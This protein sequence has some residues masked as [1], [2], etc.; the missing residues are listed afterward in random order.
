[1]P[2][3]ANRSVSDNQAYVTVVTSDS[4]VSGALVLA[5]SLAEVS[6]TRPAI[7][8]YTRNLSEQS[9][10]ALN[11]AFH[12]CLPVDPIRSVN[13]DNLALLGRPEL[14]ISYTKFNVWRLTQ[15]SK[16]VFMD[17]DTMVLQNIDDLFERPEFSAAPDVGW[18]DCFN[19]GVFVC[20]PND[21]TY[22]RLVAFAQDN[23]S[24]D[25]G[26]QGLLND[27]FADWAKSPEKRLPFVYNVTPSTVYTYSPAYRRFR[28]E[29][30]VVHFIGYGK[31]WTFD[32]SFDGTPISHGKTSD[33][34]LSLIGKWWQLYTKNFSH[35]GNPNGMKDHKA[36]HTTHGTSGS[37]YNFGSIV[38]GQSGWSYGGPSPMHDFHNYRIEWPSDAYPTEQFS[39]IT[40]NDYDDQFEL[41]ERAVK[42]RVSPTN[43]AFSPG[44]P[45][46]F[47]KENKLGSSREMFGNKMQ[48]RTD[49][50]MSSAKS[51]IDSSNFSS[52]FSPIDATNQ[53]KVSVKK[54]EPAK[55]TISSTPSLSTESRSSQKSAYSQEKEISSKPR[56][57]SPSSRPI[58][59]NDRNER[60][61]EPHSTSNETSN[62]SLT[63]NG[64]G[65]VPAK[66]VLSSR[67]PS[68][69]KPAADH[70]TSMKSGVSLS[71]ETE[72]ISSHKPSTLSSSLNGK[73]NRQAVPPKPKVSRKK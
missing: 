46:N 29:I 31:P 43:S 52:A 10:T 14:D 41:I 11:E 57:T 22:N 55:P 67:Q 69:K 38:H 39:L 63:A 44:L 37:Y 64:N 12:Q 2:I 19:S 20:V 32:R 15:F 4:Y 30:K 62:Y 3:S 42:L 40:S 54:Q 73:I 47:D 25:G 34:V 71:K 45:M 66:P 56:A 7:C 13:H 28:D 70:P 9:L 26:D 68:I 59:L 8:L 36:S 48:K 17:A 53:Q 51:P 61:K 49:S 6:A 5:A 72:K 24:F 18:P 16:V 65:A 27:F 33:D 35:L 21:E 50:V 23:P 58:N 1:M 60:S